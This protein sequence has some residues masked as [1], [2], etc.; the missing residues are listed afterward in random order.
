[1]KHVY[2]I[3]LACCLLFGSSFAQKLT[4][5]LRLKNGEISRENN[6]LG[7]RPS[8]TSFQYTRYQQKYYTIIRFDQLPG[9][10]EKDALAARG[11]RLFDY[12]PGN[13][14]TAEISDSSVFRDLKNAHVNAIFRIPPGQK[15]APAL[16]EESGQRSQVDGAVIAVTFFGSL[17]KSSVEKELQAA[18]AHLQFT[19]IQPRHTV[20]VK[21]SEAAIRRMAELPFVA[22][23]S[24]QVLKDMPL[25]YNNRAAHGLDVLGASSGRN[26]QGDHVAI[27]IGDNSDPSTHIDLTG[28]LVQR[29]PTNVQ[30]H[31]THTAGTVAG[32]G[33]LNPKYKGMSPHATLISQYFSDILVNT[34]TYINDYDMVL[35]NNSYFSGLNNCPG[36]GE[37]DA[38]A[39]YLDVQLDSFPSLLHV[40]AA[41]NDGALTCSPYPLHFAT[42]KSGFQCAK[43]VLSVGNLNNSSYSI[44]L[45]SSRGPVNDGRLKPE[46]VAGG[47]NIIS[48][49]PHN[50]YGSMSGTSMACPTVTGAISLLYERY[51][52]LHAGVD[53]SGALIKAIACNS[54]DDLGNPGPDF[55]YGFGMLNAKTAVETMDNNQYFTGNVSNAGTMNYSIS[56]LPAGVQ[57]L[58][59]MLYWPDAAAVPYANATLV[60]NLDL[61]V[62]APGG[63]VHY[64]LILDPSPAAVNNAAVEG[65]DNLNNIEQVVINN[66]PAGNFTISVHGTSIPTGNQNF[67]IAYQVINPSVTLMYPYGNETWVPGETEY[68]RW[69]A[70]GTNGNSFSIDYSTDNGTTWTNISS[71]VPGSSRLFAWT[72]PAIATNTGLIRVTCNGPGYTDMSHYNFSILGQPLV[73]VSKPCRGY[74]QLL[75]NSIPAATL[76]EIM[77]L[78]GDSMQAI[79]NTTDTTYLLNGLNP[80][81]S[82]WLGVRAYNN[83]LPG[84]RSVAVN[85][86]PNSGACSGSAFLN[87]FTADS[88]IAPVT[89]RMFTSSQLGI[90]AIQVELRNLG[91]AASAAT[92]NISYQ[93]N[94][95]P[96]VTENSSQVVAAGSAYTYSF[97][98]ANQFD[99]STPGSYSIKVWVDYPGDP[100]PGNDTLVATVKNLQNDPVTLAPAFTEGFESAVAQS[101][102]SRTLGFTGLDRCDFS[103]STSN[104]RARTFINTGFARTGNRCATLDQVMNLTTTS[105][106]SMVMTFNLS[107]FSATD[108]IWLDYYCKNQGIDFVLPG[109]AVWIR[110]NDQAAWIPAD[111]LS[112][113]ANDIGIYKPSKHIDVT[114]LLAAAGP[115]QTV[116]SSFQV[117]FGEQGYTSTNSVIPDGDLDN[118]YSFDDVT[119]TKSTNDVGMIALAQPALSNICGLSASETISVQ[120]RN[121]AA[122]TLNN[123]PISY[124]INGATVTENIAS[125]GP[126]QTITYVFA[127]QAD[128]SAY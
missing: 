18:G 57:Q 94:G 113:N 125:I 36:E 53:P 108:Q 47:T 42:I 40:F 87:D 122:T 117:K 63:T 69:T 64:P 126:Q 3:S 56:G 119:L 49:L 16:T 82:Y 32:G 95:G 114:G 13:A 110:G 46:I 70:Y 112:S 11:I 41:G 23:I 77:M 22:Y 27:G 106:D 30:A 121:Y 52:Q 9:P 59:I 73:T 8:G 2:L 76:Y 7:K 61:T 38:L 89:G 24:P 35:T 45:G 6:L 29:N 33:I 98:A 81:S 67:A 12:L 79:D 50:T 88:L 86:Q 28:R 75:W 128:L 4:A 105:A 99:F 71:T 93:V 124:N 55:T 123:I 84:R 43:N 96:V 15:L 111:T 65:V 21:A 48:T 66:P 19:K 58:K 120:V 14:F 17:D 34:P 31:G 97:S 51:R 39:N 25:N 85:V 68:I 102:T 5:P 20:F 116:S 60:N 118:G 80:D 74:A 1:M 90:T 37:Y 104:G 91:S 109:N 107:G 26:L 44:N 72:V 62:T 83:A 78:K 54:A 127:Q 10:S 101:Y 103:T 100:Q 92:F 115:A